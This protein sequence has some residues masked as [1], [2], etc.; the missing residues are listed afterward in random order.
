MIK[1]IKE[2]PLVRI[3]K[4]LFYKIIL[5][6]FKLLLLSPLQIILI[7]ILGAKIGKNVIIESPVF[8]N[9]YYAG[10]KNLVIG[11]NVFIGENCLFD[12]ANEIIIED[13]VTISARVNFVT[14]LNVG[15]QSH[16]LFKFFPRRD[17]KIVI[18]QNSFIG[19]NTVILQGI[20]IGDCTF[21]GANSLLNASTENNSLYFGSP[22]KKIRNLT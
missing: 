21:I 18:K 8:Y 1:I 9:L 11:N 19:T 14:H 12:L 22:A 2:I 13:N 20:C 3:Y 4:Y 10:F 17:G 6:I 15:Y 5:I 16:K 7:R